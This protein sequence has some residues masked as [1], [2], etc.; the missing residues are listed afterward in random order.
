MNDDGEI[1]GLMKSKNREVID[2]LLEYGK[3]VEEGKKKENFHEN[4]SPRY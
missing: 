2:M 3:R 4:W 1:C